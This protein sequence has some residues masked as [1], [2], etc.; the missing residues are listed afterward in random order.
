MNRHASLAALRS[1][2]RW[3][4]LVIGGGA[5]GLGAAVDAASRGYRTA[6]IEQHDFAKGTS[7]RS[8]K[9]VHGG[10]RYLRQGNIGLV[11]E[12][13][14][15]RGLLL[16]NAPGLAR[17]QSFIIPA[18][19]QWDRAFYGLG[20][21]AYDALA[22]QHSLGPSRLLSRAEVLRA[23][24]GLAADTV[25]GGVEYFDGQFDDAGLALALVRALHQL[26]GFGVN[27]VRAVRLL[28]EQGKTAGV[29]AHDLEGN[30]EFT[31]RAKVV[32]N[33][34]GVF[35]DAVRQLDDASATPL[36]APSQGAHIV[37]GRAF[38]PANSALMVPKTSDG[39]VLFAIPWMGRLVIGTT[40]TPVA[41]PSLE[42]RSLGHE[43]AFILE[44]AALYLARAPRESDIL[45]TFAG[46]RPLVKAA[47]GTNTAALARDHVVSVSSS[48]L[49]TVTGGKWTTYR[50][51]AEDIVAHAIAVGQ[52]PRRPSQ[53]TGLSLEGATLDESDLAR[54]ASDAA[55]DSMAC[56]V[57]DVLAR[58]SRLLFLDA[59]AAVAAAPAVAAV[60]ARELN[61][62]DAWA[63]QEIASFR[64]LAERY[65]PPGSSA[66]R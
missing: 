29:L 17:R 33:A 13:L 14:R 16:R 37:V 12:S 15:E 42:P 65:L 20:L 5:S 21:K 56:H 54:L 50:K 38:L 31:L 66:F 25:R 1:G 44:H 3:D 36:V 6:L 45:S 59:R 35:T 32:I 23:L 19:S 41:E 57:E 2:E 24:P 55:R 46:L 22:G 47:A 10:V 61:H 34:T 40:D 49:V 39:R 26:G 62:D 63:E 27:Y 43:I 51:M 9:L 53:T 8:T 7:S 48:G 60:L 11:R 30:D 52:L 28:K 58:R 18:H 64:Q 4:V